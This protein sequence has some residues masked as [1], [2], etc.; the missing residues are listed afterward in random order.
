MDEI[1]GTAA[2]PTRSNLARISKS[3]DAALSQQL[4]EWNLAL[5]D[6]AEDLVTGDGISGMQPEKA[7]GPIMHAKIRAGL[8]QSCDVGTRPDRTTTDIRLAIASEMF[9]YNLGTHGTTGNTITSLLFG[10]SRN[11]NIQEKLRQQLWTFMPPEVTPL[12]PPDLWES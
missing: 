2:L 11:P 4:E 9:D 7:A 1:P 5:C 3:I 8:Q 12:S 10:L 6:K